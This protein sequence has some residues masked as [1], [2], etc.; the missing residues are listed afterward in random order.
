MLSIALVNPN[1][2]NRTIFQIPFKPGHYLLKNRHLQHI[3][4]PKINKHHP[5]LYITKHQ[6]VTFYISMNYTES[7]KSRYILFYLN[8]PISGWRVVTITHLQLE[9]NTVSVEYEVWSIV[10][11]ERS[12]VD[13]WSYFQQTIFENKLIDNCQSMVTLVLFLPIFIMNPHTTVL[14]Y[15]TF[16]IYVPTGHLRPLTFFLNIWIIFILIIGKTFNSHHLLWSLQLIYFTIITITIQFMSMRR[17]H[18][19]LSQYIEQESIPAYG[20]FADN[21]VVVDG[22]PN[23]FNLK[24]FVLAVHSY[25]AIS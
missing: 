10:V 21:N 8:A 24:L 16:L 18:L 7:M 25:A 9:L 3:R 6:V 13:S 14:T 19:I 20:D 17:T 11:D 1:K 2:L 23:Y 22:S 4:T 12:S 5:I 15:L